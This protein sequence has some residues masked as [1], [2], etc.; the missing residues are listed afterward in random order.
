[1]K[2]C[3][4]HCFRQCL[5]CRPHL[6]FRFGGQVL[7]LQGCPRKIVDL[8]RKNCNLIENY[9][10]RAS[11]VDLNPLK[12]RESSQDGD[13]RRE[14]TKYKGQFRAC[15]Q[16]P[17]S[18]VEGSPRRPDHFDHGRTRQI[19]SQDALCQ[20]GERMGSSSTCQPLLSSIRSVLA[21]P[22]KHATLRK[23]DFVRCPALDGPY[24]LEVYRFL[25]PGA[26]PTAIAGKAS[27]KPTIR[28]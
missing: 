11:L 8:S 7:L 18:Q 17:T 24:G 28:G 14:N 1:M 3:R 5:S 19:S 15:H 26:D 9:L 16:T 27:D 12:P 6:D 22:D 21:R 4:Q 2:V 23:C 25:T 10:G 13:G 20:M